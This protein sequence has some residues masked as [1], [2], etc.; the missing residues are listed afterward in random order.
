LGTPSENNWPEALKLSEMKAGFPKFKMTPMVQHT[1]KLNEFEID[2]LE[3]LVAL[4]PNKR[5]SAKM[6]LFHPYFD[7]LDKSKLLASYEK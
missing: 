1:P 3:G 5:I 7:T 4:D 2:L 6:A